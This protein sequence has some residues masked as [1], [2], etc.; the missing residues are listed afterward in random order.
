MIAED[1]IVS[2][3]GKLAKDVANGDV[4][5]VLSDTEQNIISAPALVLGAPVF[6]MCQKVTTPSG[7][8]AIVS[9]NALL[10]VDDPQRQGAVINC[11][12]IGLYRIA[13]L[14]DGVLMYEP[15]IAEPYLQVPVCQLLVPGGYVAAGYSLNRRIFISQPR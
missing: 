13:V 8:M 11:Q 14:Y 7:C 4:L 9:N 6:H 2:W 15:A 10:L 3:D 5:G 12:A 1:M